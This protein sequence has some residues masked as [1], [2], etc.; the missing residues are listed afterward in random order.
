MVGETGLRA[1]SIGIQHLLGRA[2]ISALLPI[3]AVEQQ[4]YQWMSHG[5]HV[6]D[7]STSASKWP[8]SLQACPASANTPVV[9]R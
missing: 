1:E 3:E 4:F 9:C 2:A 6:R 5:T 8:L 7:V